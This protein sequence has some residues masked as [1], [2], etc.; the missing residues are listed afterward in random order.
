M[1]NKSRI[2]INAE[3]GTIDRI[4]RNG[5]VQTN[6]GSVVGKGHLL[7]IVNRKSSYAH[8]LIYEHVHGP[9]PTGMQIDHINEIK[10]DNRIANLRLVTQ[11][12]NFQNQSKANARNSVGIKGVCFDQR[13][14]KFCAYISVAKRRKFLGRFKNVDVAR[15][16]YAYAAS[17]LHTHNPCASKDVAVPAAVVAR[18]HS[19]AQKLHEVV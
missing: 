19:F 15:A 1:A 17:I 3:A 6:I 18:V 14:G 2:V 5:T 11:S 7:V 8:R 9:I 12:Q 4:R 16:A 13:T 10:T